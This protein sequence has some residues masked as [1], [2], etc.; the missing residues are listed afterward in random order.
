MLFNFDVN[1]N[2]AIFTETHDGGWRFATTLPDLGPVYLAMFIPRQTARQLGTRSTD[3]QEM[4]IAHF[5]EML[6]TL[7]DEEVSLIQDSFGINKDDFHPRHMRG[8]GERAIDWISNALDVAFNVVTLVGIVVFIAN[9]EPVTTAAGVAALAFRSGRFYVNV[10]NN[11]TRASI[12]VGAIGA[13]RNFFVGNYSEG[14]RGMAFDVALPLATFNAPRNTARLLTANLGARRVQLS[15]IAELSLG[16]MQNLAIQGLNDF[17]RNIEAWWRQNSNP[18]VLFPQNNFA[19]FYTL[20][21]AE[22]R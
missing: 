18:E 12:A 8:L 19:N 3:V 7:S 6:M 11:L 4:T 16:Q 17:T 9:P 1:E 22:F 5:Y 15:G 21:I 2:G 14:I 10:A 20:K 13:S